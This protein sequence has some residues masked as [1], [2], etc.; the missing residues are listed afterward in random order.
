MQRLVGKNSK[1][2]V[3]LKEFLKFNK[4]KKVL[5]KFTNHFNFKLKILQVSL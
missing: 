2:Y 3:S 5:E 4:I 1:G